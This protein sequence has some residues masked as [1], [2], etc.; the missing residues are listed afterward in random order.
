MSWRIESE[1]DPSRWVEHDGTRWTADPETAVAMTDLA[2]EPQLLA[3]L[4][5]VYE[6]QGPGDEI[7]AFLCA[8]TLIPSPK[9][10]GD[11]PEVPQAGIVGGDRIVH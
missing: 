2:D 10:S 6:P 4:G 7:A 5:P 11:P 1:L 3:P 9:V 8:R